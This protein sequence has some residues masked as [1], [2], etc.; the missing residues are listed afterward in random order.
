MA[1]TISRAELARLAKVSK[2][3]ITKRCAKDLKAALVGDR[4]DLDHPLV[5]RFL[6][7]RGVKAPAP[8]RART[9]PKK[10][11]AS[12][13]RAPTAIADSDESAAAAPTERGPGD[14]DS[15]DFGPGPPEELEEI[16]DV[17]RPL[18]ERFGTARALRDWLL[19]LKE[20]EIIRKTRL[21]NEDTEGL[22]IYRE[23]M[24]THVFGR[25]EA[26][27]RRL[28]GDVPKTLT[29]RVYALHA[30]GEPLEEAIKVVSGLLSDQLDPMKAAVARTLQCAPT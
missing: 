23:L 11:R 17:L 27:H 5:T 8:A 3:A 4:I 19:A 25:I 20:I 18:L 2:P 15:F 1:R 26:T 7:D 28:L 30:A 21:D 16:A 29:S 12:V 9:A 10:T 22:L 24:V 13:A 6:A 14:A